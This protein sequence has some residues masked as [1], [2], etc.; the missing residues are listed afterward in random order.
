MPDLRDAIRRRI[1]RIADPAAGAEI[2]ITVPGGEIWV[3]ESLRLRFVT[4][5]LGATETVRVGVTDGSVEYFRTVAATTQAAS[6]TRT[7]CAFSGSAGAQATTDHIPVPW[8]TK[9]LI[10]PSGHVIATSTDGI[11]TGDQYSQIR[12]AVLGIPTGPR[13]R[14]EPD[15]DIIAESLGLNTAFQ[16]PYSG[17]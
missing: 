12:L 11:A 15:V 8:P 5:A 4:A 3:V 2:S 16:L 7:Y 13:A 9:G 17:T 6:T 14:V 1:V 10:L